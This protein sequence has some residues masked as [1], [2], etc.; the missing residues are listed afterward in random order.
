M[1]KVFLPEAQF[2]TETIDLW[3]ICFGDSEEYISF[4][5]DN[6]PDYIGIGYFKEDKLVAMCFLLEGYINGEKCKYLYAACTHPDCRKQGIMGKLLE[7]AKIYCA[8]NGY[9]AI[10]LVPANE[11]LYRYYSTFGYIT[12]FRK[13]AISLKCDVI[14]NE[15]NYD[16]KDIDL[17]CRV[18]LN[19]IN[20]I[21]GFRFNKK[22]VKY[23]VM[24]HLYNGGK[25]LL[26]EFQEGT[27]LAFYYYNGNDLYVKELLS[28]FDVSSSMLKKL[29]SNKNVE[30]IYILSPIVYNNK[31]I[32]EE[33][34]KCGMCLPLTEKIND[35]LNNNTEL[36]AGM[37]LD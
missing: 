32:G 23:T 24:E 1:I 10:F 3:S 35:Y 18:K 16:V 2:R 9:S 30:N 12:S 33:Y 17:I 7:Y 37:Y 28:D 26:S 14:F 22:T 11:H 25:V 5:I 8:E 20:T 29:F 36:Y 27:L 21:K 15:N 4:F 31:D 13:K 34:T 6:C 19:L